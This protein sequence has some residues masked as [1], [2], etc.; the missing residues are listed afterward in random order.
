MN[1]YT[2]NF[3]LGKEFQEYL[4]H[5]F[6]LRYDA[7]LLGEWFR[8]SEEDIALVLKSPGV[9]NMKADLFTLRNKGITF[10]RMSGTTHPV[11]F[12]SCPRRLQ[13]SQIRL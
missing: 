5:S 7:V 10:L 12:M 8:T 13:S 1:N 2:R 9:L 6:I 11:R 4:I 3:I